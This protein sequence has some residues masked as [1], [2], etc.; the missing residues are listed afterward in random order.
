MEE[1]I[2]VTTKRNS[3]DSERYLA[4]YGVDPRDLKNYELIVNTSSIDAEGVAKIIEVGYEE[5]K[6]SNAL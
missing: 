1:M 3:D 2:A 6:R 5:W 4:L